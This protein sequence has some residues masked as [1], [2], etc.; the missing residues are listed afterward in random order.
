[1]AYKAGECWCC[2]GHKPV[3][4]H[5]IEPLEY[6]GDK[7]GKQVPLCKTCHST[8]HYE[9]EHYYKNGKYFLIDETIPETSEEGY[10]LR[11]LARKIV[12]TKLKWETTGEEENDQ[13]R[14]SQISW[15]SQEE[16]A[17]AHEVKRALKFTALDRALKQ[18]VY[19]V[20]DGLKRRGK[21]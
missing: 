13:R 4:N 9:A 16:L 20:Y 5:H 3:D 10:R 1:M 11:R 12:A 7:D 21:I 6:G 8:A 17:M 15:D 18:C 19:I 2:R 14:M